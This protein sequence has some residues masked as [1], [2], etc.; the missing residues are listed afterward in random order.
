MYCSD[1]QPDWVDEMLTSSHSFRRSRTP[2]SVPWGNHEMTSADMPGS[3]R[4]F[5]DVAVT[6]RI[7]EAPWVE[8]VTAV[9]GDDC[10][11]RIGIGLGADPSGFFANS[12][13]PSTIRPMRLQEFIASVLAS[14]ILTMSATVRAAEVRVV[15]GDTISIDGTSFRLHG[16]DAPEAGQTCSDAGGGTWRCGDEAT[17]YLEQLMGDM[18]PDC[19]NRGLDAYDRVISVCTVGGI[20][21]NRAMVSEGYAWAFRRYSED[22][23]AEEEIAAGKGVQIWQAA[24][25]APWDYRAAKWEVATQESP[26]GCPIKGNISEN[27]HI[28]HAPWSPWYARTK[29]SIDKGEHWF[30]SEREALDAGWRAP[31][32][33]H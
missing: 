2:T 11:V 3:R 33:G 17:R 1:T 12:E 23:T 5:N 31:V 29:I 26:A 27:G 21:L 7:S 8:A 4:T 16:I 30:C 20:E 22:Y 28:Y 24:T 25:Q 13:M 18:V 10:C 15:D 32:W 6:Y 19:D 14:F 9:Q